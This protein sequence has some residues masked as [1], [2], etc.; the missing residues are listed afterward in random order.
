MIAIA[1]LLAACGGAHRPSGPPR[2]AVQP[3]AAAVT[4]TAAST[5]TVA[6][7]PTGS[8]L[9]PG[10]ATCAAASD[11]VIVF[12]VDRCCACGTISSR[13]VAASA[14][15]LMVYDGSGA[16]FRELNARSP[17]ACRNLQCAPCPPP[18][19]LACVA[20]TCQAAP[21]PGP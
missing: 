5:A 11:C 1:A 4:P 14:S 3:P 15:N 20:G 13:A 17:P 6:G 8:P 7:W 12:A 2:G 9:P 10:P 21:Q 18:P 19:P 16:F